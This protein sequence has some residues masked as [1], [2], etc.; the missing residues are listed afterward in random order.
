MS[1]ISQHFHKSCLCDTDTKYQLNSYLEK[2]PN[3]RVAQISFSRPKGTC[4]E[5]LFVVF[6]VIE[7][8]NSETQQEK[9]PYCNGVKT[10]Y[11]HTRHT[12]LFIDTFGKS[13]VLTVECNACPPFAKCCSKDLP[14]RS[15]FIINYCPNCGRDLSRGETE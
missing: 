15:A 6:D 4:V 2:H 12:K 8:Q 14:V 3:F 13:Q 1:Q 9:C 10:E 5:D 7:P 11:Q